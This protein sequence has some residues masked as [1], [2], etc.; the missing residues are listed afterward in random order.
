MA[1]GQTPKRPSQDN[2]RRQACGNGRDHAPVSAGDTQ[3]SGS[4]QQ[5]TNRQEETPT[6]RIQKTTPDGNVW[7]FL[8]PPSARMRKGGKPAYQRGG[9]KQHGASLFWSRPGPVRGSQRISATSALYVR[10]S[11][12]A[13]GVVWQSPTHPTGP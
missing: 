7:R 9:E 5:V 4:K 3:A 10:G 11:C 13:L 12:A 8:L 1:S 6:G 2:V